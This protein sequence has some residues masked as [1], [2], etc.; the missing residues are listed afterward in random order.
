MLR[1][2]RT[3]GGS[4]APVGLVKVTRSGRDRKGRKNIARRDSTGGGG[5]R[6]GVVVVRLRGAARC[7]NEELAKRRR[8]VLGCVVV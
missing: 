6:T 4:S 1:R 7:G 5:E 8:K 2:D 3:D